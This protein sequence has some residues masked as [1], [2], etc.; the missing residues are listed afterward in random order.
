L[1][2]DAA[3][4]PNA[5]FVF[6]AGSS[7]TTGS[8]SK[9]LLRNGARSCNVFWQIGQDTTI[10][11]NSTFV[12]SVLGMRS[13]TL[14]TGAKVVGRVL[15]RNGAVTLDTNVITRPTP[16]VASTAR[17]VPTGAVSTGDGS[18][19]GNGLPGLL[20]P[21]GLIAG[22]LAF[23]G[24]GSASVVAVRRRRLNT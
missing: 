10:G 22:L 6:Q 8:G 13:I 7:L 16:C 1:T 3:G 24:V 21:L 4:D 17:K 9:I 19:S 14:T 12:G 20:G 2:L 15:A 23:A 5:V 18:T 11:T